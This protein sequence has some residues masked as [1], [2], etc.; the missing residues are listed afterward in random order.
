MIPSKDS[1]PTLTDPT[2][3]EPWRS[4]ADLVKGAQPSARAVPKNLEREDIR[5]VQVDEEDRIAFRVGVNLITL[6]A[7]GMGGYF[8]VRY[9]W[10]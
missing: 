4:D 6:V 8:L 3:V 10:F 2:D 1:P 7:L 9:L 5:R